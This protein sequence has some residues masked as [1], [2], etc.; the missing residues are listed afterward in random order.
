MK[1]NPATLFE[2]KKNSISADTSTE[3]K[4]KKSCKDFEA[5][6]LK[7]LLTTM[8]KS[9]PKGGLFNQGYSEDMYQSMYDQELAKSMAHS[10]GIGIADALYSQL[11]GKIKS[12]TK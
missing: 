5:I 1:V 8:R 6:I 2:L 7:Q 12:T 4:L 9:I 10:K 11:S 3:A